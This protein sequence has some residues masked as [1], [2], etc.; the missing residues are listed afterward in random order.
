MAEGH[1]GHHPQVF[2][3][4]SQASY[5][6]LPSGR[7]LRWGGIGQ[8]AIQLLVG[9]ALVGIVM[10]ACFIVHLYNRTGVSE[11]V[12]VCECVSVFRVCVSSVCMVW[13]VCV[14]GSVWGLA[15]VCPRA[16]QG[17]FLV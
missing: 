5:T 11:G 1:A 13:D 12:C 8:R 3:V 7:H 17:E 14:C 10:E 9:L 4:D 2:V 6:P 16:S 15:W